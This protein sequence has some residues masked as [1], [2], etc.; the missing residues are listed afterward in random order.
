[1]NHGY[2]QWLFPIREQGVNYRAQP[3]QAHEIEIIAS[4]P[5]VLNRLLRSY[6]MMLAFYGIDFNGGILRPSSE[7]RERL[8]NLY[9]HPH[10]LLRI[11]RILKCISE[12]PTLST[13]A[14]PLALYFVTQH[15]EGNIDLS[16]GTLHGGSL[17]RWWSNCFRD[18]GER[19]EVRGIVRARGEFGEGRWGR[20][21]YEG[22]LEERWKRVDGGGMG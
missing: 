1:V 6:K 4:D 14:A 5:T 7:S 2:I 18:E 11:T 19:K 20:A 12:F 22:W 9:Y 21:E 3:L 8:Q 17:D 10:N 13:H 15:S 16:E